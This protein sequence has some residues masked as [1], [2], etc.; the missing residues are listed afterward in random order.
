ML[1]LVK[2]ASDVRTTEINLS[3]VISGS[4][5]TVGAIPIISAQGST[6]P[7]LQTNSTD[8]LNEYG[9]PNPSVSMTIQSALNYL[10]EGN[11]I[12]CLRV[13]GT[14]AMYAGVLLYEDNTGISRLKDVAVADPTNT[15]LSTL[16]NP[17]ED[18]VALFYP[19][20]GPGSYGNAYAIQ[21]TTNQVNAPSNIN[22][23]ST[24]TG[25]S[26][27]A[28]TYTYLVSSVSAAGES[29]PSSPQVIVVSGIVQPTAAVT[30][31]WDAVPGAIGYN[32]YGR[33]SPSVSFGF[34]AQ[35]GSATATFKDTGAIL[36]D[37][38]RQPVA[39]SAD[40]AQSDSFVVS[41]FNTDNAQQG[42]L[43]TWTCTLVQQLS[44]SG[45]QM[46]IE[47]RI[48]PFS[49]YIQVVSNV[50]ALT[51]IPSIESVAKT[52]MGGG[53][54]GA[55]PTTSQIAAAMQVFANRELYGT[56]T[57]ING[58][59]A[60]PDYQLAMDTLVQKRGDAVSL[61]DVPSASQQ[62][63]SAIDYRNLSLN[64]NSTY[65]ALFGPDVLQADL[66]NGQQV[67]VPM[68][69]WAGA[70]CART[71]RIAN[72]AWSIAGLN[73]GLLNVLKQRYTF[74]DGPATAL[75]DAQVN[76]VRTF[77]GQGIA[78]WEQQ[79]LA[80]QQSALSWLNVRRC[81]NAIKVALYQ[82]LLYALQEQDTDALRRSIVNS[83]NGYLD[84]WVNAGGLSS[85]QV[86]CDASNNPAAAVNAAVLV[87]T[88]ILVPTLAVHEVQL[89]V[90]I[91]KAGVSFSETLSQV[92]GNTQ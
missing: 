40:A 78:L 75:F 60:V 22:A 30:L 15:D 77:V 37:T 88:V 24:P 61:L 27:A 86:V 67:Y 59:I 89:Q 43:E 20:H 50:P 55:T 9:N 63:Q 62:F 10:T 49:Q 38:G 19:I 65:S 31:T 41:V 91:S 32:I 80:A 16:V 66:I 14:G 73:R 79:T 57:F 13:A 56:N 5:V 85:K 64:L 4:S 74:D 47:D 39:S 21:I 17:D 6:K 48:N 52:N 82:Y 51:V 3:A 2:R 7:L 35:V 18:A 29:M 46:Y 90:V 45:E 25:G 69:G 72:Q 87:V 42:A 84:N 11:Q 33:V 76:Y 36:P 8:L 34:I 83:L 54:S 44:A 1:Q 70:L 23:T 28:A 68:S 26:L 53:A 81:V 12:Y 92:T 71:D 58:G